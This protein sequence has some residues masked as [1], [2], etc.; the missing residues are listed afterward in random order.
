MYGVLYVESKM[1]LDMNVEVKK[2]VLYFGGWVCHSDFVQCVAKPA[3]PPTTL[4]FL[5]NPCRTRTLGTKPANSSEAW[6]KGTTGIYCILLYE[7]V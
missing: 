2:D 6:F 1:S 4:E 3:S 7:E 5:F